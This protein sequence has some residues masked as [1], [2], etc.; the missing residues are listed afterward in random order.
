[1]FNNSHN[2]QSRRL[3]DSIFPFYISVAIQKIHEIIRNDIGNPIRQGM[4]VPGNG[5]RQVVTTQVVP[6][7]KPPPL[8]G[9]STNVTQV[10]KLYI[11]L[12]GVPASFDLRG[13]IIGPV[14]II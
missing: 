10:E 14:N 7:L 4:S 3:Y 12:D 13:K 1:M 11:G 9:V 8:M 2:G 6:T 5:N